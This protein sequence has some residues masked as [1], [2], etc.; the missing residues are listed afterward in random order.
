MQSIKCYAGCGD[1]GVG[2]TSLCTSYINNEFPEYNPRVFDN[3]SAHIV[4]NN[5]QVLLGLVDSMAREDY[6]RLRPL[7]YPGTDVF[8]LQFSF[9]LPSS[10][11]NIRA[12]WYPEAAHHCPQAS[13]ILVGNKVDL[14]EDADFL[15]KMK[16]SRKKIISTEDG[17]KLAKEIKAVKYM[18]CSAKTQQG[19]KEVFEEAVLSV[20]Q[21]P[22][23]GK[24]KKAGG[25][26]FM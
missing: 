17:E 16:A 10:F 6:D 12:K 19:L 4:V 7:S 15:E 9:D 14:R 23:S 11:E 1:G 22:N 3:Y 2:K 8:L 18:E 13:L 20:L 21:K 25:C 26:T 24:R 5:T